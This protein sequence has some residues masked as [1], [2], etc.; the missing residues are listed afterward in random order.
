VTSQK[1]PG[2][3]RLMVFVALVS[4]RKPSIVQIEK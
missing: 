4:S 3:A 1:V 2:L